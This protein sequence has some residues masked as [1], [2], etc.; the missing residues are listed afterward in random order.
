MSVANLDPA[1]IPGPTPSPACGQDPPPPSR[2]SRLLYWTYLALTVGICGF[3]LWPD[4]G[5]GK[6]VPTPDPSHDHGA[7]HRDETGA[8]VIPRD[9]PLQRKLQIVTVEAER[10]QLPVLNV[11][12]TVVASLRA[13]ASGGRDWQFHSPELLAT[14][15]DWQKAV[16]DTAFTRSQLDAVRE[17]VDNRIQAQESTVQRLTR[18]VAAGTETERDLAAA[19]NELALFRIQGRKEVYEAETAWRQAYRT[20]AALSRQLEQAGLD[21]SLLTT[22]EGDSDIVVADVPENLISM[23]RVGQACEARFACLGNGPF[24]GVVRSISPVLS[25][26]RR[27]LRVLFTLQDPADK[28]R[29]GMFAEIGLGTEERETIR[30]PAAGL[31]HAGKSDYL[32]RWD[33]GERWRPTPVKAGEVQADRVEILEGIRAGDQVIGNGAILLKPLISPASNAAPPAVRERG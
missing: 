4:G 2:S 15:A 31:I 23:V 24:P 5:T 3:L 16:A 8:I 18:L 9:T 30:V 1:R 12:G 22:R 29:P 27:S 6:V 33:G 25:S 28:L 26:E 13:N 21:T 19:K 20:E 32:F 17:L 10:I 11:T 14:Y 7:V